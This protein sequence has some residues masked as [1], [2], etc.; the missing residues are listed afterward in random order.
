MYKSIGCHNSIAFD[1][2]NDSKV[3][4]AETLC[5]RLFSFNPRRLKRED[6]DKHMLSNK[7]EHLLLVKKYF[8]T[9]QVQNIRSK[10]LSVDDENELKGLNYYHH[11]SDIPEI[12]I[13]D[14]KKWCASV[15]HKNESLNA[16]NYSIR[17]EKKSIET[18]EFEFGKLESDIKHRR[19][20]DIYSSLSDMSQAKIKHL[21][22]SFSC[23][24]QR[25]VF[26]N[27]NL[28]KNS[29]VG[30]KN[31]QIKALVPDEN[32]RPKAKKKKN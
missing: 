23:E 19:C 8:N 7:Y 29:E 14:L 5:G 21:L 12:S 30:L 31:H 1:S 3:E 18:T 22:S 28:S 20:A 10:K 16:A 15:I 13:E 17:K 11:Y 6:L 25:L 27:H 9:A 32:E 4:R 26:E 24:N 2:H